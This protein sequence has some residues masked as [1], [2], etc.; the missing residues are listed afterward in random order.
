MH[1]GE[2]TG[3]VINFLSESSRLLICIDFFDVARAS[4]RVAGEVTNKA[5]ALL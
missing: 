3:V 1:R 2:A 4:T 5:S